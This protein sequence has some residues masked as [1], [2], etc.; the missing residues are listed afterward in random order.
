MIQDITELF[1]LNNKV[2]ELNTYIM[3]QEHFAK[4]KLEEGIV[5]QMNN[6]ECTVLSLPSDIL[7]G[8]F[9][10]IYKRDDGSLFLYLVDGQGHGVSPALTV[11]AISSI[12]NQIVYSICSLEELVEELHKTARTFLGEIEQISYTMIMISPDRKTLTYASGGMYPFLIKNGNETIRIKANNI[13]FMNFSPAP[14]CTKMQLDNWDSLL[15]Y[16]DGIM[17][18][19]NRAQPI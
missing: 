12:I 6:D 7:S 14:T 8:D 9:Y 3:E 18:A 15:V 10:S 13:P 16:S 5:N 19:R 11:F 1:E 4:D 17:R 2:E